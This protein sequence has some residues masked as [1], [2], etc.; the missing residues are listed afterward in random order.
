MK[1]LFV[2]R[3]YPPST[4]GM[5]NAAYE[6]YTA[7]AAKH[8]VTLV[9][10]GGANK[11]L[12]VVYPWLF[13]QALVSALRKRPDV[14]YMQDG[15][16]APMGWL[17]RVL[18]GRPTVITIHGKEA[19]YANPV[20][21]ILVPSF[22]RK[23][24]AVVAVSNQTKMQAQQLLPGLEVEVIFN[25]VSDTFYQPNREESLH[26]VAK[27][28]GM[29]AQE[30]KRY[31]ILHTNG[32]LV[33]RKGVL[34]F[35]NEVMPKLVKSGQPVLYLVSGGGQDGELIKAAVAEHSLD[36]NVKLLGKVSG[37]LLRALYNAADMFVMANIPVANDVEGFGLVALE[38]A[39]C[40][41]MVVAS[42]LEG[43]QDAIID[44]KNGTLVPPQNADKYVE[45][46]TQ[47][48][49][50][51]RLTRQTVRDY[52]LTNYAWTKAAEQYAAL[53]QQLAARK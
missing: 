18:T 24:S 36:Q 30:L 25:G 40:G 38:A 50:K 7:L 43:I 27:V 3:K 29:D 16:M 4:G 53:M 5:E 21:K 11:A 2:T 37:E 49:A 41:T 33:R 13:V 12:P 48:I 28:L 47:E 22:L 45:V 23:Q 46:I 51:P 52:T 35:V 17:L 14:I 34:W 10:W 44:G 9:K 20:Y 15:V 8:D 1:I 31:K 32:R 19:T 26:T 6:L 42:E 39:S